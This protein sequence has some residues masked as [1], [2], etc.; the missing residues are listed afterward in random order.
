MSCSNTKLVNLRETSV[1]FFVL[2]SFSLKIHL[3]VS[4]LDAIS[5]KIGNQ[6]L[7]TH[8]AGGFPGWMAAMRN[9]EIKGVVALGPGVYVF[10][11]SEIPVPLP[12]LT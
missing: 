10:P 1:S 6:V 5:K 11:D 3:L 2:L 12:S 8:S 7:V 4:T 9:P